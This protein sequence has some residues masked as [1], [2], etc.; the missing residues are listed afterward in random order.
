MK[1]RYGST[2]RCFDFLLALILLIITIPLLLSLFVLTFIFL[3]KPVIYRQQ[4]PGQ[5][6]K[7]FTL[8]KFRSLSNEKDKKGN[9]LPDFERLSKYGK[10]IRQS[11]LDELPQLLNIIKGEMSFVGPRPLKVEYLKYYSNEQKK[12]HIVKPGITG[13]AQING[14]NLVSWEKKL[15]M[16]NYYV[17]HYNFLLDIL[18]LLK[19]LFVIVSAKNINNE[20]ATNTP[21]TK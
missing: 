20:N 3:G 21:F 10:F 9:L 12:R 2:K 13:Y 14:R 19:T 11:S 15:E 16:D 6:E 1:L 7:I 17:K 18:I 8:L 5:N 4:R